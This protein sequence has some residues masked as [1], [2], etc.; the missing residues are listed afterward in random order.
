MPVDLA[1]SRVLLTGAT[2]GLGRYIARMLHSA[3]ARLIL[4]GRRADSLDALSRE[5]G[6]LTIPADLA[7]AAEVSRVLELAGPIDVLIANAALPGAGYVT[8]YTDDEIDRVLAINLRA[9]VIMACHAARQMR[10]RGAG[11]I[12][13]ISSLSGIAAA[14]Q[15]AMYSATK[16]GLRGFAHAL[17]QDL[18]G[19][20]VGV[21]VVLPGFVREAGMFADVGTPVQRGV[22]TVTPEAVARSVRTAIVRDRAE[23]LVAPA[24]LRLGALIGGIAP[25]LSAAAQ[26]RMG[27]HRLASTIA[28]GNRELGKR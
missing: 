28:A 14:E 10:A 16:F 17:R 4:T 11:Q 3:G 15:S 9:P 25:A 13:L 12:V 21:S 1:G 22:R 23:T 18:H 27:V 19:S 2:G 6:G 20:G 7:S 5:V 8:D 24:E 26:R